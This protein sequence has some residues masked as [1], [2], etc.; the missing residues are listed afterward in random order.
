MKFCWKLV[1]LLLKCQKK[2]LDMMQWVVFGP[3]IGINTSRKEKDQLKVISSLRGLLSAEM[4]KQLCCLVK[5]HRLTIKDVC[6]KSERISISRNAKTVV[7]CYLVKVDWL[8][9]RDVCEKNEHFHWIMSSHSYRR[10]ENEMRYNWIFFMDSDAKAEG[11][12]DE[13]SYWLAS[14]CMN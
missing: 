6:E 9:I 13:H 8:T 10:F 7:L 12:L 14:A 1:L 11:I 2:F 5:V 3:L 4:L